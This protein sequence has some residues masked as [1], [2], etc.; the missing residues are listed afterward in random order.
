MMRGEAAVSRAMLLGQDL[1]GAEVR[2]KAGAA[3]LVVLFDVV[4]LGDEDETMARRKLGK[5]F[6]DVGKELD[7]LIG[8]GLSEADDSR[9]FVG[10]NG[11]VG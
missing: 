10:C 6:I 11:M 1:Y 9:V 5:S 3:K 4:A 8:N 2:C 7:L